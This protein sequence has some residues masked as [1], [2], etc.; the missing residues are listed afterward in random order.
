MQDLF[1]K[2]TK[3]AFIAHLLLI[4]VEHCGHVSGRGRLQT[5]QILLQSRDL[6]TRK[7]LRFNAS[8]LLYMNYTL[9]N[10]AYLSITTMISE[11]RKS[12]CLISYIT[13]HTANTVVFLHRCN[14][15]GVAKCHS[16]QFSCI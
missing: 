5:H 4:R 11:K 12:Q 7:T 8:C 1:G 3:Q 2:Q 14:F 6:G 10:N 16:A 9:Q 13:A 15:V